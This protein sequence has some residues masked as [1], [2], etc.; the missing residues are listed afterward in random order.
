M[1]TRYLV[2]W[3]NALN[4]LYL[5]QSKPGMNDYDQYSD[6]KSNKEALRV[7]CG[8]HPYCTLNASSMLKGMFIVRFNPRTCIQRSHLPE[9]GIKI[10]NQMNEK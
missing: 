7:H 3:I 1:Q 9:A 6:P 2:N 10:A 4:C 5:C 8:F